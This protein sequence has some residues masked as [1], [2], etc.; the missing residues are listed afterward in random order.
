[1][2]NIC[3]QYFSFTVFLKG[4]LNLLI[5]AAMNNDVLKCP[6]FL[7]CQLDQTDTS[8]GLGQLSVCW[9]LERGREVEWGGES[10]FKCCT[11]KQRGLLWLCV[12]HAY[13]HK[14]LNSGKITWKISSHE[15]RGIP[16][17]VNTIQLSRIQIKIPICVQY[18]N[19]YWYKFN[20]FIYPQKYQYVIKLTFHMLVNTRERC[21]FLI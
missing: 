16:L 20:Q 14:N 11:R 13:W 8:L 6:I 1:M 18:G 17:L 9:Y 4:F 3:P 19:R 10:L 21:C 7:S 5:V 2:K 15:P 12:V